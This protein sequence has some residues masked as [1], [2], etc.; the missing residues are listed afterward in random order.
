MIVSSSVAVDDD[1]FVHVAGMRLGRGDEARAHPH[2]LRAERERGGQAAAVDDGAGGEHRNFHRVDD[3]RDQRDARD[4]AGVAAGLRALRDDGVEAAVFAGLRVAHGAADVHHLETGRV[5]AIDEMARRHAEARDEGRR[6]FLDDDVGGALERFRNGGEQI[7]AERFLRQLAHAAHL[8]ADFVRAAS[9]HAERAEAA[10]LRHRRAK[11]GVGDAAHAGE[12]DR[13]VDAQH[14]A[15]GRA[16]GHGENSSIGGMTTGLIIP[17]AGSRNGRRVA[18]SPNA[19]FALSIGGAADLLIAAQ[20][21][22]RY[23]KR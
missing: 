7:D 21:H 19:L 9:G 8:L 11:F 10:G 6:A 20:N 15:N 16:D 3:L 18:P 14:V 2:A 1:L 17:P 22:S 23:R 12:Q 13:V 4:L 5:E